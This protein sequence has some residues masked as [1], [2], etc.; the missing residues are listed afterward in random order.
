[1]NFLLIQNI[2][3][4]EKLSNDTEKQKEKQE[5]TMENWKQKFDQ[6]TLDRGKSS[7]LN[8][9]VVDLTETSGRYEAAVLGRTRVIASA[10]IRGGL[11]GRM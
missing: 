4:Y 2:I 10:I 8:Q 3:I 1:M 5:T 11:L 7:Y 9:R 6:E